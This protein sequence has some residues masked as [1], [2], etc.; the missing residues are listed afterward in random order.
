MTG[1]WFVLT[2]GT[3]RVASRN[4]IVE[5]PGHTLAE[6]RKEGC[7]Q[8]LAFPKRISSR[9]DLLWLDDWVARVFP[10]MLS[11]CLKAGGVLRC[12]DGLVAPCAVLLGLAIVLAILSCPVAVA[13]W[14]GG[15]V[16]RWLG[17]S[18]ALWLGG[19]WCFHLSRQA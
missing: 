14:L 5:A 13:R 18:V 10:F 12:M 8:R 7:N 16:A 6:C 9:V 15:S 2:P 11:L 4:V 3:K 19:L 1:V 17:G